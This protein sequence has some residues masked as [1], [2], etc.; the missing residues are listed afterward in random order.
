MGKVRVIL[1]AIVLLSTLMFSFSNVPIVQSNPDWLSD[2]IY[3]KS[4]EIHNATG[5]GTNYQVRI[6]VHYGSGTDSGEDVYLNSHCRTDFGDIRFTGKDVFGN[7]PETNLLDYW[8]EEKVD[9]NYAVFWV[10]LQYSLDSE[11]QTI[12][13]Y[14]GKS[15]ATYPYLASELA[16]G[17]ATFLFF[18]DFE[19]NSINSDKWATEGSVSETNGQLQLTSS[20]ATAAKAVGKTSYA[21]FGI[22]KR[23]RG[24][25]CQTSGDIYALYMGLSDYNAGGGA[26]DFFA[27]ERAVDLDS[28]QTKT[29]NDGTATSNTIGQD[30]TN[31]HEW[32]ILW[33][34]DG[35]AT[36]KF[37]LDG[38]LEQT[39]T[40]NVPTS[41]D[42]DLTWHSQVG[43]QVSGVVVK[44]EWCFVAK[45]VD[46]EPAH[47]SWGTEETSRKYITFNFTVGGEIAYYNWNASAF[48]QPANGSEII[49]LNGTIL[50]L[51]AIPENES[52]V[53][54]SW[55]WTGGSSTS[56]PYNYTVTA[57]MTIWCYFETAGTS[58]PYIVAR[59]TWNETNP[60][61]NETIL[62]DASD[63]ESSETITSYSWDWGDGSSG[64]GVTATHSYSANGTYSVNLTI[65]SGAGSDWFVQEITIGGGGGGTVYSGGIMFAAI[66]ILIPIFMIIVIA[67]WRRR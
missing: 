34:D 29:K 45:Y 23:V 54:K 27:W 2:W 65:T 50:K 66:L 32:E 8:I 4:H 31:W 10:E 42:T 39:H 25:A 6:K 9:S 62:F 19:D 49:F 30:D 55:N 64:S 35:A 1:M 46:P 21:Q 67:V 40:T 12:Y 33:F 7:N 56:N 16:H 37:Y 52:Y 20:T 61:A 22:G 18:D 44:L 43:K 13:I 53:F 60:D 63:S 47:G 24:K 48:S 26:A 38:T 28:F 36:A 11:N 14:Y 51:M 17:E 59:F 41:A 57:N 5:A 15:D 3:R 58:T